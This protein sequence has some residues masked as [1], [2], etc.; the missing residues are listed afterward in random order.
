MRNELLKGGL[1]AP[2]NWYKSWMH[3][4]AAEDDKGTSGDIAHFRRMQV[5]ILP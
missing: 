1:K 3:G 4:I 2:L 5:S